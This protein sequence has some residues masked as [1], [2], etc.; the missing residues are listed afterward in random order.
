MPPMLADLLSI[1][2]RFEPTV[3]VHEVAEFAAAIAAAAAS[4][5][6]GTH[7]LG[8]LMPASAWRRSASTSMACGK[9]SG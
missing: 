7:A 8:A 2:E 1:V 6:S 3:I 9:S 5:P 4:V